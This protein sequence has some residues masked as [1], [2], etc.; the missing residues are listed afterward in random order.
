M[1]NISGLKSELKVEEDSLACLKKETLRKTT[2]R[3]LALRMGVSIRRALRLQILESPVNKAYKQAG[4]FFFSH[5]TNLEV[6]GI[7][8]ETKLIQRL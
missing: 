2:R 1:L 5:I 6:G 4:F 7:V 8:S 3:R